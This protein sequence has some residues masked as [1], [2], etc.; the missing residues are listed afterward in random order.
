MSCTTENQYNSAGQCVPCPE[1]GQ[2]LTLMIGILVLV[3]IT[4][5]GLYWLHESKNERLTCVRNPLRR[6]TYY[7]KTKLRSIG[8]VPKFKVAITFCQ[9]ISSLDEM[10]AVGLPPAGVYQFVGY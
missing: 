4:C 9:V 10:Y 6:L 8:M 5:T 3:A 2:G 1:P 7:A